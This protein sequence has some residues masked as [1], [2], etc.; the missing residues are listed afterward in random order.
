MMNEDLRQLQNR[1][2]IALVLNAA[3]IAGEFTGGVLIHSVG[4]VSDAWHNLIDQG[5]LF[6]TLY[7]HILAAKPATGRRTFG[8]HRVGVLTAFLNAVILLAVAGG[9][10]VVAVQRLRVPVR[11][12]GGWVMGIAFFS[13]LANLTI[14]LLLQRS[15]KQDLNIRSAFLHM[16]GDAWVCLSVVFSGLIILK[17]HWYIL[18]PVVSLIVVGAILVSAW[19]ILRDSIGILLDSAPSGLDAGEVLGTLQ[20]IPGIQDVH[21]L[22]L[23]SV[24]LGLP[25]LTCHALIREADI[26]RMDAVLRE[27]R[28]QVA[29]RYG[30]RHITIQTETQC[31][32]TGALHCA[33]DRLA[34]AH[35]GT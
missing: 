8:Y 16:L 29:Q 28:S 15:A 1:L 11:V 3:I 17:T 33:L 24:K 2:Y 14:A 13:F 20:R 7:A 23:W 4:L 12:P 32:H 27:A 34:D 9:L 31:C 25:M 35:A 22:H 26:P 18:D 10:T 6:L 21:D 30:I 5:S 19:P